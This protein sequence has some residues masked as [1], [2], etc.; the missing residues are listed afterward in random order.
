VPETAVADSA[1]PLLGDRWQRRDR[2]PLDRDGPLDLLFEPP[3]ADLAER[4]IFE[5]FDAR[6][7]RDPGATALIDRAVRLSY[8]QVRR[9]TLNLARHIAATVPRKSAV[10]I[11]L[12]AD[13]QL[14]LAI[15]A[16][17]A[18]GRTALVLNHRNPPARIASIIEDAKPAAIIHADSGPY[19]DC[20]RDG[21]Q[22]IAIESAMRSGDAPV[23]DPR[24]A[25]GPDDPAVVL[26][27]SGSTGQPKGIVLSQR[28]ILC[29]IGQVVA[30]WH[31]HPRDR[32][33]SLSTPPTIPGLTGCFVA[34]LAGCAQ[35]LGDP[36]EDGMGRMLAMAQRERVTILVG[37]P[38]LLGGFAEIGN[39]TALLDGLRIVRTTGDALLRDDLRVWRTLL[40]PHCHVMT[41][42]GS[43]EMFTFAQWFVPRSFDADEARLP[44]GYPLPD[45]EFKVVDE[46][47]RAVTA[48]EAGELVL[49]SRNIALGE[50]V[51]G[52][53]VA[54]RLIRDLDDPSKRILFTGDVVRQRPDGLIAFVGR[55][56]A[57]VKVRGQR[58]ELTEIESALRAMAE[59]EDAAVAAARDG[60]DVVLHGFVVT[61][62][63]AEEHEALSATLRTSLGDVLPDYMVPSTLNFVERLPRL[64]SGKIDRRALLESEGR[65]I[66]S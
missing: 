53:W 10:G 51:E 8:D 4:P 56:D 37:L 17:L 32:F 65:S 59:V 22:S 16:C 55:R 38:S 46:R 35:I 33:L 5:W 57:Q 36:L 63:A 14:P 40:P 27:T 62:A 19:R 61:A 54:G 60:E 3:P 23:L 12:R 52:R 24:T 6:A 45:H 44:V 64:A 41:T 49:R 28:A 66:G 25:G 11:W 9:R 15:L 48:G 13:A 39:A 7:R 47:G 20:I 42:F 29:R 43:T 21:I 30:A 1:I 2:V 34:L 26:Y 50:W 58:V 31:M 18:A